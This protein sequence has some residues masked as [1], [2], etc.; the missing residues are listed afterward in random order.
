MKTAQQKAVQITFECLNC[1]SVVTEKMHA[2]HAKAVQTMGGCCA[3]CCQA[4][5]EY[6]NSDAYT[7]FEEAEEN[8]VY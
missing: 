3:S 5:D 8:G 6:Y 4:A 2:I 7:A 1:R